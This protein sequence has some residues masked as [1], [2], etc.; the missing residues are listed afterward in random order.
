M[1]P[2]DKE[3]E[4]ALKAVTLVISERVQAERIIDYEAWVSSINQAVKQFKGFL[5]VDV[6]RPRE[7]D[8]LEYVVILRFDSYPSL[9][10]WQVST[11]C[12][13]WLEKSRYMLSRETQYQ[14][15]QG[16]ELWFDLAQQ[17]NSALMP[18]PYYKMVIVGILAVYPLVLLVNLVLGPYLLPLPYFLNVFISVI[19]ISMLITYPVMPWLTRSLSFWLY[20][21]LNKM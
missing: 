9:K 2:A 4:K 11:E 6:I 19:A 14:Q 12:Q 1:K 17:K 7:Q 10:S 20:P 5:G 3:N 13:Y 21:S 15:S 18:A 8:Q 16:L